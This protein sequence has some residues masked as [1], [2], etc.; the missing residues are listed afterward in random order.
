M[1]V[2][3]LPPRPNRRNEMGS[4]PYLTPYDIQ[5]ITKGY[6]DY[7]KID[8]KI[9]GMQNS[10]MLYWRTSKS[11]KFELIGKVT[12]E[13]T[14]GLPYLISTGL[15]VHPEHR[16]NVYTEMLDKAKFA[17][18]KY[19]GKGLM[20]SVHTDNF[21]ELSRMFKQDWKAINTT[22]GTITFVKDF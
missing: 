9:V 2:D 21:P 5:N 8:Q 13:A 11:G 7:V 19:V 4:G 14:A 16:G 18:A 12:L 20:A 6:E 17:A 15:W 1:L 22:K 3:G 10:L